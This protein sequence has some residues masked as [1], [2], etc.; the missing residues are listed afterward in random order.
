[1]SKRRRTSSATSRAEDESDESRD[2]SILSPQP[3]VG[4][5]RKKL[6]PVI[7]SVP[8]LICKY[9]LIYFNFR[10]NYVNSYTIRLEILKK[11]MVQHYA[12]F[13]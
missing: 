2:S 8:L 9:V 6:D 5:K 11:M 4:R 13:S 7:N 3:I 10:L 1:M 12:T